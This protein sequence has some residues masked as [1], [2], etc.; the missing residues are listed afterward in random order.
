MR[1]IQLVGV[2]EREI[3][4][5]KEREKE[6]KRDFTKSTRDELKLLHQNIDTIYIIVGSCVIFSGKVR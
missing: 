6:G 2:R 4:R 1:G 5:E 3:D